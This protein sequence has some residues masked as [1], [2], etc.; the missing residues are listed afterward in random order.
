[1]LRVTV[2]VALSPGRWSCAAR[3]TDA[4]AE[5][6]SPARSKPPPQSLLPL[7][8]SLSA[9]AGTPRPRAEA[10]TWVFLPR[11]EEGP[12]PKERGNSP[13][14]VVAWGAAEHPASPERVGSGREQPADCAAHLCLPGAAAL[15][16]GSPLLPLLP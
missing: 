13:W 16:R 9:S 5:P 11:C 12:E 8:S 1:M 6:P 14:C 2:T 10:E 15:S 7:W 4:S 3:E